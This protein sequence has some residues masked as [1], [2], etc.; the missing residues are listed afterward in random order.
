M[1]RREFLRAG[2]ITAA[3]GL[4]IPKAEF[5]RKFFPVGIDLRTPRTGTLQIIGPPG[6]LRHVR[7]LGATWGLWSVDGQ[8]YRFSD[9]QLVEDASSTPGMIYAR[10]T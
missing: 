6:S 1:Q 5:V 7:V 3:A 8:V 4:V 2:L 9:A 10:I